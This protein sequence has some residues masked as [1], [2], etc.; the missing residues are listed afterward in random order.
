MTNKNLY[1]K[2]LSQTNE[3]I[4]NPEYKNP[5]YSDIK[6]PDGYKLLSEYDLK[7]HTAAYPPTTTD[8]TPVK[9]SIGIGAGGIPSIRAIGGKF[10]ISVKAISNE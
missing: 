1:D 4:N 10:Y 9:A 3:D 7:Y 2:I 6:G 5:I 8:G